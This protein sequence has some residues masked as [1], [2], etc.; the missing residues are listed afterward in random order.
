[1]E[2]RYADAAVEKLATDKRHA[3]RKLGPQHADGLARRIKQLES[4][5]VLKD[6]FPPAGGR[7]HW[8]LHDRAGQA[9]GTVKDAVRVI[10]VPEGGVEN[11]P[12]DATVVTVVEISEHY[13]KR[14]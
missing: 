5:D 2:V 6:V 1:M 4:A 11:P 13:A 12:V 9:A 14:R 7:W 10:V 3:T 8:L